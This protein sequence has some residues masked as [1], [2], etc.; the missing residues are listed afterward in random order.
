[1]WSLLAQQN[2]GRPL[3]PRLQNLIAD[4][5]L[6][7]ELGSLT[8]L[9]APSLRDIMFSLE[10]S[11]IGSHLATSMLQTISAA[12]PQL[13]SFV[14]TGDH[15]ILP[16]QLLVLGR[17]TQLKCL[18]LNK[19]ILVNED[20]LFS[21]SSIKTLESLTV[22][23]KLRDD[24]T[25][26][27]PGGFESLRTINITASAKD[28]LSFVLSVPPHPLDDL[29]LE[30]SDK[31]SVKSTLTTLSSICRH[32]HKTFTGGIHLDFC[33]PFLH[34]PAEIVMLI[35][36][37]LS[38]DIAS[39]DLLYHSQVP[40]VSDADL[41][42]LASAWPRLTHL[43]FHH[44]HR[45]AS[46]ASCPTVSG[47]F[48]LAARLPKLDTLFLAE[49]DALSIPSRRAVPPGALAHGLSEFRVQTVRIKPDRN[50]IHTPHTLRLAAILDAAFP[51]LE[52]N[53]SF[54]AIRERQ[55]ESAS[56]VF[57]GDR[58]WPAV[59]RFILAMQLGRANARLGRSI[60]G[61]LGQDETSRGSSFVD[62]SD[63][64]MSD[65][66]EASEV[67]RSCFAIATHWTYVLPRTSISLTH[68]M[69]L[70]CRTICLYHDYPPLDQGGLMVPALRGC[71]QAQP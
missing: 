11:E 4:K 43:N 5:I 37:V 30:F 36:P 51:R 67:R 54:L 70:Q 46:P 3:L 25:S 14:Y 48:A 41:L 50:G 12:I 59:A 2:G 20:L 8:P 10:E 23:L 53:F 9:L 57:L 16:S 71:A 17:L 58:T 18:Q 19:H 26:S 68:R 32:I 33:K 13:E 62:A 31:L 21:I 40:S 55:P 27:L 1:M 47:I 60:K 61:E 56:T 35:E 15:S 45:T 28:L 64:F 63:G 38:L 69:Q 6:P 22:T 29:Y 39:F 52:I 49:F 66:S 65:W 24:A 7:G 34:P 44:I 42:R